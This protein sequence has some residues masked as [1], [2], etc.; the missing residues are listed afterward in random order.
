MNKDL[1]KML[2]MYKDF[3][4]LG[5]E[6]RVENLDMIKVHSCKCTLELTEFQKRDSGETVFA[7][8]LTAPHNRF[9]G[10]ILLVLNVS[11]NIKNALVA[12]QTI[13]TLL[14]SKRAKQLTDVLSGVTYGIGNHFYV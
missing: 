13:Y 6:I 9:N 5:F 8:C 4:K 3:T 11:P 14:M 10:E 2:N 12:Y 1:I 7:V